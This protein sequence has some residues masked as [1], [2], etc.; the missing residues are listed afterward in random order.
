MNGIVFKDDAL[1]SKLEV[2]KRYG[3]PLLIATVY[4]DE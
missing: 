3:Q 4:F 1:V 2:E